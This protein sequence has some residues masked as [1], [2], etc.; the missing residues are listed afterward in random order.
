MERN[1]VTDEPSRNAADDLALIRQMMEAGRQKAAFDG[2]HLM[3]WGGLL[4]AAYFMQYLQVLNYI[5]GGS[6]WIWLPVFAVGWSL[7]FLYGRKAC[8][9]PGG[10]NIAVTVY[11]G[12]WLAVG[13]TML[14]HF[15]TAVASSVFDPKAITVLAC[16]VIASAFYVISLVTELKALKLVSAGWWLIMVF[17]TI[18]PRY[19]A[20]MLLVLAAASALLILLPGQLMRRM[21]TDGPAEP[22]PNS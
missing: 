1:T 17:A 4:A 21:A 10:P 8:E 5:P 6:L 22:G 15:A 7:S 9:T 11:N 2:A 12:A 3:I 18:Q 20:E 14:L 16:G 13:I 19:D